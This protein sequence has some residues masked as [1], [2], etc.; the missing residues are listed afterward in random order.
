MARQYKNVKYQSTNGFEYPYWD[1]KTPGSPTPEF[2]ICPAYQNICVSGLPTGFNGT[3][4]AWRP[5]KLTN[6]GAGKTFTV[7]C[8]EIY[9][10]IMYTG[11]TDTGAVSIIDRGS[12]SP[13]IWTFKTLATGTLGCGEV[14]TYDLSTNAG[15]QGAI[16]CQE[17]YYPDVVG[18][19]YMIQGGPPTECFTLTAGDPN[20]KYIVT[21]PSN[22][23]NVEGEYEFI[24][25]MT[26]QGGVGNYS[27]PCTGN[28][29]G[30]TI[31]VNKSDRRIFATATPDGNI[32]YFG[33]MYDTDILNAKEIV[34]GLTAQSF[35]FWNGS[36]GGI[37]STTNVC[38]YL[39][40]T[41]S[42]VTTIDNITY[43]VCS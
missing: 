30:Q 9:D 36:D 7:N 37:F 28:T 12:E 18:N 29:D 40:P 15:V 10:S 38:G 25:N 11:I 19:P 26:A 17:Y 5:G 32:S 23:Y 35:G 1:I 34:C 39:L 4:T 8:S 33:V 41:T 42:G 3:Y 2:V 20:D 31:W 14:C 22:L 27:F 24:P 16:L 43:G 6:F 13:S 21:A